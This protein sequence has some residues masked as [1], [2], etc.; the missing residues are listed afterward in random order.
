MSLGVLVGAFLAPT[1]QAGV[2]KGIEVD[3]SGTSP[4]VATEIEASVVP[5]AVTVGLSLRDGVVALTVDARGESGSP[6]W[7][8]PGVP[9][10]LAFDDGIRAV[11]A[12][13]SPSP[14]QVVAEL[15]AAQLERLAKEHVA[16]FGVPVASGD[17]AVMV[18]KADQATLRSAARCIQEHD[19]PPLESGLFDR[20]IEDVRPG[21]TP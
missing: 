6:A 11:W 13:G 10:S 15:D 2:C 4:A 17:L 14:G 3:T 21:A 5:V 16:M 20:P 12:V 1:A 9:L 8:R 18:D 19:V 7:L